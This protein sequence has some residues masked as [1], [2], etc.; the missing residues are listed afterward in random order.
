[1]SLISG[2]LSSHHSGYTPYDSLD[3]LS[4]RRAAED[5]D[6]VS[7]A[8]PLPGVVLQVHHH[9]FDS[10]SSAEHQPI[11]LRDG[12]VVTWD[13]RLDNREDLLIQL[14]DQ[15]EGDYSDA[16]L[17]A[18][19]YDRWRLTSLPK[20]IGDW[21][22]A[23]WDG[24]RHELVLARDYLGNRPLY[25]LRRPHLLAWSTSL[26][27]LIT[28][29]ELYRAPSEAYIAAR[30]FG[31]AAGTLTPYEQ[32]SLVPA[33]HY[34]VS[35]EQCRLTSRRFW[36]FTPSNQS[37]R[38][39]D[40]FA[41]K[42]RHLFTESVRVRL[43]SSRNV[44]A[45]LSGGW[46]SSTVVCLADRLI[47]TRSVEA[48]DLRTITLTWSRSRECDEQAYVEAVERRCCRRTHYREWDG[49]ATLADLIAGQY[50]PTNWLQ[51]NWEEQV[52]GDR[53][54]I[55]LTGM[56]G[57]ALMFAPTYTPLIA[58]DEL[59]RGHLFTFMRSSMARARHHHVSLATMLR[60]L[61]QYNAS[62]SGPSKA[63]RR[64]VLGVS[65][66]LL[67]ALPTEEDDPFPPAVS[68]SRASRRLEKNIYR[69]AHRNHFMNV[70]PR[71]LWK[72]HPFSHRPLV[73]FVLSAPPALL[74]NF[75]GPRSSMRSALAEVLPSEVLT[76]KTKADSSNAWAR[77]GRRVMEELA[78]VE[79]QF[80]PAKKWIIVRRG[81]VEERYVR[82]AISSPKVQQRFLMMCVDIEAWLRT[83]AR[84]SG[85]TVPYVRQAL[86]TSPE[87]ALERQ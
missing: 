47:R 65:R 39:A 41:D 87:T 61:A 63:A 14:Q 49:Y 28:A 60:R 31:K 86:S 67:Q 81:Y 1:V 84:L 50:V 78:G 45:H 73:E 56:C 46:D 62:V 54:D 27:T 18:A 34:T 38:N 40:T 72:T 6:D 5:A 44:W 10:Y 79:L 19:A 82:T 8:E 11:V 85:E 76:R 25:Q 43:R 55:V 16:A 20:L 69:L 3:R 33:G 74:W 48:P 7:S 21:S 32:V 53:Q 15:L 83:L 29:F 68:S 71:T 77:C 17:V 70:N 64:D 12:S 2:I 24:R 42:L 23:I 4:G 75:S 13:G 36:I 37:F 30:F 59:M 9:R 51:Y 52:T 58:I 66:H 22:V 35:D 26:E 80:G 57:D